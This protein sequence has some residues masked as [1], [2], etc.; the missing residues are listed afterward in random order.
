VHHHLPKCRPYRPREPKPVVG[1]VDPH[2]SEAYCL[3]S[4]CPLV[5]PLTSCSWRVRQSRC[6]VAW[7]HPTSCRTWTPPI[8]FVSFG[9]ISCLASKIRVTLV[10]TEPNNTRAVDG[11][12]Q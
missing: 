3:L 11:D 12:K 5:A 8:E 10:V 4:R 6:R 1:L 2:H 7:P 9:P